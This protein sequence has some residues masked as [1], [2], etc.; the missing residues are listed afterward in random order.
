MEE[1][2]KAKNN[3]NNK[4]CELKNFKKSGISEESIKTSVLDFRSS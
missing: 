3:N 1:L 2:S 4:D